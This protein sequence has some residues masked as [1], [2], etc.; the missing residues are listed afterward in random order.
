LVVTGTGE[1]LDLATADVGLLALRRGD[2]RVGG[3][4]VGVLALGHELGVLA[5]ESLDGDLVL[6]NGLA[7]LLCRVAD[8]VGELQ[9]LGDGLG[10]SALAATTY[11][12]LGNRVH[13]RRVGDACERERGNHRERADEKL[14]R[15]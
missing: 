4:R 13:V 9:G 15:H 2:G 3:V 7:T 11:V 8:G 12:A 6:R 14:P 5:R 1:V 10:R